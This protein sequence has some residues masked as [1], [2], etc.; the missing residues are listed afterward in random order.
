M[1]VIGNFLKRV[2]CGGL[3]LVG[4]WQ[5]AMA[6]ALPPD[7]GRIQQEVR[8]APERPGVSAPA[9][10]VSPPLAKQAPP[11]GGDA[12]VQV[13]QF[14]FTGNHAVT[15]G[16][17]RQAVAAWERRPLSFGD[18]IEAVE[19]V[20]AYY[21]RAGY[22]LA[23]A[24]LPPQNIKDGAV[25][26]M[27]SEGFLGETRI[28]GESRVAA[29]VFYNY[30][31]RLPKGLALTRPAL[32]RQVLLVN[33][34][35]GARTT[36]D[37]QAGAQ[38]GSSDVV[39][40]QQP[41]N[42]VSGRLDINNHG[43]PATGEKRYGLNLNASSP[44]NL[45]ERLTAGILG[46]DTGKLSS[47]NLRGELP[48]GGDGWRVSASASRA[49][50]SLGGSFASLEASGQADSLR[51]GVAYPLILTRSTT[52]RLQVEVDQS[53]L[54]D[55]FRAGGT[56]IAKRSHGFTGSVFGERLD[57]FMGGGSSRVD[58]AVRAGH[59]NLDPLTAATDA[60]QL[61]T[62]GSYTKASLGAQR[63][64]TITSALSAL[65]GVNLQWAG[66]NLDSSEKL[67]LGGPATLPGYANGEANGDSGV[68]AKLSLRWQALPALA[69]SAF[70][71]YGRLRL[72]H[73]PLPDTAENRKRLADSGLGVDWQIAKGASASLLVAVAG[74]EAPN[75]SDNDRPRTWLKIGYGW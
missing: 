26:I 59:L 66:K 44:F 62:A 14:E 33:E 21:K 24:Y 75:A 64:Q 61:R 8:P 29:D 54:I 38:P 9:I 6:Q 63:Q 68:L 7:A 28:E 46:T 1:G 60:A 45:G 73:E 71:N 15:S 35:A 2:C 67:G 5:F 58:F 3:P 41:E 57:E 25:Q 13:T 39:L 69:L 65:A 23:Q 22:I 18:L 72:A 74:H 16:V 12:R 43:S 4:V 10:K 30:L 53:K 27:V 19:A 50:Y 11:A 49:E 48:L 20:E 17:L 36:L 47:Y 52:L 70:I 34:L 37:L 55:R 40:V 56:E 31:N 42:L 32:E 51:L